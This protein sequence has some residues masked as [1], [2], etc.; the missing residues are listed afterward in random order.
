MTHIIFLVP[1]HGIE[2]LVEEAFAERDDRD[3]ITYE[4]IVTQVSQIPP[5][6][7]GPDDIIISRGF[8]AATL[9]RMGTI[10]LELKITG[11]DVIAAVSKCVGQFN[12]SKIAIVGTPSMIYGAESMRDLY[13]NIEIACVPVKA[14][15]QLDTAMEQ[16]A[17]EGFQAVVGG[18]SAIVAA[19][20]MGLK[21]ILI[22]SGREAVAKAID[23]AIRLAE[24]QRNE[25]AK[26]ERMQAIMDYTFEGIISTNGKGVITLANRYAHSV[27]QKGDPNPVG[28]HL[29]QYLPN[30]RLEEVLRR[31]A[32]ILS[33]IH[34]LGSRQVLIN[35]VPLKND[36]AGGGAIVAFQEVARIQE[37]EG[38]LRKRLHEKG[39]VAR[40]TFDSIISADRSTRETIR[41]AKRFC[42]S[43]SN[44]LIAGETGVGKEAFAQS[45]HNASRRASQPFVAINCASFPE[46]LLES[47]LF[48]YVDGAFTGAAKGGKMGLFEIAHN[49][50]LFLDEVGDIPST[51][52]ARL[53]RVIQER[54]II[55]IG[56]DRVIPINVRIISATNKDLGLEVEN[57]I[58]RKDLLH[59]L[60]VL[61]LSIQPLRQRRD[62]ILPLV[63]HYIDNERK[64]TGCI[65]RGISP[66]AQ[67]LLSEHPWP[68]NVREVRN[69]CERIC[70]FG[71]HEFAGHRDVLAALEIT[72]PQSENP[73]PQ[74]TP[75]SPTTASFVRQRQEMES[76]A[77]R[78]ALE[79][80]RYNRHNTAIELGIDKSTLWRKMKKYKLL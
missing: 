54:E 9:N 69:F 18:R 16:V 73:L 70:V 56:G 50:T 2:T 7:L 46:A 6:K 61:K 62:D 30:L 19:G 8:T 79:A 66:E 71:E 44:L 34:Q 74:S 1:Y 76:N 13:R 37:E 77:L 28:R 65:L 38:R 3:R 15:D 49:G 39:F 63:Q 43:D 47:E 78:L 4:A 5:L 53:L 17:S 12:S 24:I 31:D 48:G 57:N 14:E 68:G 64:R 80:N 59:R 11:Y 40:Y 67:F 29:S 72:A 23:E 45:I 51:L 22:E 10:N 58:F 21:A 60:V 35:C 42:D 27:L 41:V 36:Q 55:R 32:K 75:D 20:K 33:E 26:T 52:Q 25:R